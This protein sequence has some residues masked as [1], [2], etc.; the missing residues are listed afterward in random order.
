MRPRLATAF[1]HTFWDI[2]D[3]LGFWFAV[4]F[5]SFLSLFTVVFFPITQAGMLAAQRRLME[6]SELSVRLFFED[7]RRHA[8]PALFLGVIFFFFATINLANLAFYWTHLGMLGIFLSV[9]TVLVLLFGVAVLFFAFPLILLDHSG[10]AALR[11]GFFLAVKRFWF[12]MLFLATSAVILFL[13][14]MSVVAI[15]LVLLAILFVFWGN[16]FDQVRRCEE[17]AAPRPLPEKTFRE[18]FFPFHS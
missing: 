14:V 4:N 8:R 9:G 18:V 12:A 3:H 7:C 11:L 6:E 1:V 17:K 10:W 13:C 2:F 15:P 16:A 5:I